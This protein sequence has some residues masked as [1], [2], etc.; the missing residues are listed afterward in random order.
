[1][2]GLW[3]K[4]RSSRASLVHGATD[5]PR[6]G[7][8]DHCRIEH[9]PAELRSRSLGGLAPLCA[10]GIGRS[11]AALFGIASVEGWD[12]LAHPMW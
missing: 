11:W 7:F 1:M 5:R 4:S 12:R 2:D 3:R 6:E 8:S 9:A 10:V